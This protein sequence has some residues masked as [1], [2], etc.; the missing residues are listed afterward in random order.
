MD[1]IGPPFGAPVP[2]DTNGWIEI[3]IASL[4]RPALDGRPVPFQMF[5]NRFKSSSEDFELFLH[6]PLRQMKENPGDL[7]RLT[8]PGSIAEADA[9]DPKW[10]VTTFVANH[11]RRMTTVHAHASALFGPDGVHIMLY[12][13]ALIDQ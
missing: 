12:K 6:D 10:H 13:D 5:A 7:E 9:N 3:P 1:E 8:V 2:N 11:H 4:L